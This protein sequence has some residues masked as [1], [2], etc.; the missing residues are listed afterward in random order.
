MPSRARNLLARL[1][2]A[3]LAAAAAPS[4]ASAQT[5]QASTHSDAPSAQTAA[6]PCTEPVREAPPVAPP[7]ATDAA[8]RHA[9]ADYERELSPDTPAKR[10]AL[11]QSQQHE[12]WTGWQTLATDGS[13]VGILLLG[14]TVPTS[15]SGVP[16]A[17]STGVFELGAPIVHFARGDVA[18]G[19]GSIAL[20]VTLPLLG[21]LVGTG[22]RP[23][24]GDAESGVIGAVGGAAGAVAIDA[25]VLGWD[26]WQGPS[27][28]AQPALVMS[29]AF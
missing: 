29:A 17:V 9:R 18:K 1:F 4:T 28:V 21:Y 5:A 24:S 16:P 19:F 11:R 22:F 23:T 27:R 3:A 2:A 10:D 8:P 26:R 12:V 20:R 6:A 15:A 14:I 13:A 7:L 25:S